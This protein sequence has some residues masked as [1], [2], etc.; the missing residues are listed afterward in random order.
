[1]L[2]HSA[3]ITVDLSGFGH[4]VRSRD[5]PARLRSTKTTAK[6]TTVTTV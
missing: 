2:S 4:D 1:M 5:V 6:K 3:I